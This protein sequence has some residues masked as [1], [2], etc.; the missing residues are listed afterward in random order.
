MQITP[1]PASAVG[2]VDAGVVMR[3]LAMVGNLLLAGQNAGR[4]GIAEVCTTDDNGSTRRAEPGRAENTAFHTSTGLG[5]SSFTTLLRRQTFQN[6]RTC[7]S[8]AVSDI[9]FFNSLAPYN[10]AVGAGTSLAVDA[11]I[12]D[13]AGRLSPTSPLIDQAPATPAYLDGVASTGIVDVDL[14]GRSRPLGNAHDIGRHEQN[15]P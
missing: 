11:L 4:V 12:V 8:F 10:A 2:D 14:D 5:G 6:K 15:S 13:D 9:A 3:P 7:A 1:A